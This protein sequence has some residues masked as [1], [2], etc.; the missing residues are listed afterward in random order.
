ME[1]ATCVLNMADVYEMNDFKVRLIWQLR[2]CEN[3]NLINDYMN[4]DVKR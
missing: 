1:C 4:M 3:L 2:G